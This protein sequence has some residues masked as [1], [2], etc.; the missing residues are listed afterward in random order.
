MRIVLLV[1]GEFS[2]LSYYFKSS[3]NGRLLLHFSGVIISW[4][5]YLFVLF[6]LHL[7][8]YQRSISVVVCKSMNLQNFV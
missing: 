6:S 5:S 4:I 1:L 3:K 8:F 7:F 2:G